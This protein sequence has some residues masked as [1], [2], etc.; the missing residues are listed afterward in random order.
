M[1]EWT[2]FTKGAILG[3]FVALPP[4]SYLVYDFYVNVYRK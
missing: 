2:E 3:L 4:Y 1:M